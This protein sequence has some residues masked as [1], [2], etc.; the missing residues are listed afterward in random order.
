MNLEIG[1]G[2]DEYQASWGDQPSDVRYTREAIDSPNDL[3][4]GGVENYGTHSEAGVIFYIATEL[5]ITG[6]LATRS[7]SKL[8]KVP[9]GGI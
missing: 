5:A 3:D 9:C 7:K 1:G 2:I 6:K 4:W 8:T